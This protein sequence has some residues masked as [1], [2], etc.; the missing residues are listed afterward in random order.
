MLGGTGKFKGMK[1]KGQWR[2]TDAPGNTAS[3]FAF[4]LDYEFDWTLP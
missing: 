4:T 2:V 1:G 3:L